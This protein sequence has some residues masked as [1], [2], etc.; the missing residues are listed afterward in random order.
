VSY[1]GSVEYL[2]A[3]GHYC[4]CDAYEDDLR[5]CRHCAKP[6]TYCHSVDQT[7]GLITGD[8]GT[9]PAPKTQIRTDDAWRMDHYG[10]KYAIRVPI[11]EPGEHWRRV[12]LP[13]ETK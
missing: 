12:H 2:C 5:W 11:Y 8:P 9:Q 6:I 7:N 13:A 3:D 1:E 4:V 10:T